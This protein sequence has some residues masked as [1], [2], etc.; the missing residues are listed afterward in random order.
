[1]NDVVSL[2]CKTFQSTYIAPSDISVLITLRNQQTM[3]WWMEPFCFI[4]A[5]WEL[6]DDQ[7]SPNIRNNKFWI[8][9]STGTHAKLPPPQSRNH[10]KY[11]SVNGA[12][13]QTN[14]SQ[15]KD[16]FIFRRFFVKLHFYWRIP[17]PS[18]SL[19]VYLNSIA[20]QMKLSLIIF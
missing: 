2:Q 18:L 16:P 11:I 4:S 8:Y 19:V 3:V 10:D 7:I 5:G 20:C 9:W 14:P 17:S 15:Y 1:M 12:K 6:T 13:S